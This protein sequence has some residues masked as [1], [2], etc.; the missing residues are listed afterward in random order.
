MITIKIL[1][2]NVEEM[3][4]QLIQ[5][6]G[7]TA[8]FEVLA[9]VARIAQEEMLEVEFVRDYDRPAVFTP[10]QMAIAWQRRIEVR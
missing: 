2:S 1:P 10:E 5:N 4:R 7:E 3:A 9:E 6:G 8:D